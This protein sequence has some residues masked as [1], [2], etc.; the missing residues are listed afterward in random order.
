[1][2]FYDEVTIT[3][4]SWKGWNGLASGRREAGIPFWW[5]NGW[6]GGKGGAI[7]FQANK[8]ENTLL[9]YSY[10]KTFK[11]KNGEDG[12]TKDQYG[13]NAEDLVLTVPVETLIKDKKSWKILRHFTKDG[14][15]RIA[16]PWGEGGKGNIHFKDAVNQYPNFFLLGEPGQKKE[17][18]LE[19]QLLWDVGL[20][21]NPSVGKSSL[22]NCAASTKAKVA[23]YP[24]T[25]LVP[26]LGSVS[27][28]EYRFNMVDIPW[29]IPGAAEGKG[30]G[31][32]FL[33]H[34][35]KARIF[36]MVMDMSRY[37]QGIQETISLFDEIIAYIK[38]KFLQQVE[39]YQFTFEQEG[40]YLT[41]NVYA[42]KE[43][44][45]SKRV[46]FVLNKY[47]LINDEEVVEEYKNL[48]VDRFLLYVGRPPSEG[49][50]QGGAD[51][52]LIVPPDKGEGA[53]RKGVCVGVWRKGGILKNCFVTS[54]GTYYGIGGRIRALAEM[55]KKTPLISMP[56]IEPPHLS[57]EDEEEE[58]ITE[59]TDT[60]KPFL[61]ENDY[62]DAITAKYTNVFLIQ[63]P[64]ICKLVFILPRGNEEAELRFRK[65][66]QQRGFLDLFS[67][68]GIRKGDVLKIRSYYE[69]LDD[70]YIVF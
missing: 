18:T 14:E 9:A 15:R 38:D 67:S 62:L 59:I 21:G 65:Q 48:I 60:E 32:A 8:D 49:G 45:M 30:L 16:L 33:R 37:D 17:L 29:L 66:V 40:D 28:G 56:E 31:N 35:L 51:G 2:Q 1:M 46:V 39:D 47:D 44:F 55:L 24:F 58:M 57:F 10:K 34:I 70:K 23:D 26:I 41:F 12:R 43:L 54:A 64:E 5:P 6:D 19:L 50:I 52:D 20:I 11:A 36:A 27:V 25:T 22:I 61:I 4:E 42:D 13:A 3:I 68:R 69:G 53:K 63:H 7:I